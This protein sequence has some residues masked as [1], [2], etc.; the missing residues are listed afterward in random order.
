MSA[1]TLKNARLEL[2]TTKEVKELLT[3]AA[4]LDGVD[5]SSFM[6]VSAIEKARA[7]IRDHASIQLSAEAQARL[8]LMLQN[9]S[10]PTPAME[11]LRNIPRLEVRE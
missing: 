1:L 10:A 8:A 9:P 7:V 2:K 3:K 11:E 5:V 4:L 6:L